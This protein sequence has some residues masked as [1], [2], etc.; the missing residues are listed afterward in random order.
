MALV[1]RFLARFCGER[2][3]P[4]A[5]YQAFGAREGGG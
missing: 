5:W 2:G 3:V 1:D 4:P